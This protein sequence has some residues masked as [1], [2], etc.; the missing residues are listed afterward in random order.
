MIRCS[1]PLLDKGNNKA[2]LNDDP[3]F[4]IVSR[5]VVTFL[6]MNRPEAPK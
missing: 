2:I 6:K 4:G 1:L 5:F 3:E